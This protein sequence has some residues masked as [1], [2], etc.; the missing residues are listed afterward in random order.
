[1]KP[2]LLLAALSAAC[3]LPAPR[4]SASGAE[5][6][7]PDD[8]RE[9]SSADNSADAV[10]WASSVAAFI[11]WENLEAM[12]PAYH[13]IR[14]PS[15]RDRYSVCGFE[16]FQAQVAASE[17]SGFL[18]GPDLVVTAGHCFKS[19]TACEDLAIVFGYAWEIA[20]DDPTLVPAADLYTCQEVVVR[21]QT[22]LRRDY[23]VIRLD[24]PVEGRGALPVERETPVDVGD[25]LTLIGTPAG[26]PLKIDE[27]L[28]VAQ[29][30]PERAVFV[31]TGDTYARNSGSPVLRDGRIVGIHVAGA[32][33]Y[34][35]HPS[36]CWYSRPCAAIGSQSGCPGSQELHASVFADDVP[37]LEEPEPPAVTTEPDAGPPPI[38]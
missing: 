20:G 27:G 36:G 38:E 25:L 14:A 31:T 30:D 5:T 37:V 17:C 23:A 12:G 21:H 2:V 29:A 33:D 7:G 1:M 6:Y 26:V 34:V 28:V 18:A 8:R 22:K 32:S 11:P 4:E 35:K 24:R 19:S 16:P 10:L 15:L 13:R 3:T 9:V